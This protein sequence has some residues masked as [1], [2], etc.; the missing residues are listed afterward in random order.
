MKTA[1]REEGLFTATILFYPLF[2][3]LKQ[4]DGVPANNVDSTVINKRQA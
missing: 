1:V 3:N 4:T 2:E